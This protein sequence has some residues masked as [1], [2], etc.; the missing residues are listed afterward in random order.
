MK[1]SEA[2]FGFE[3]KYA[4]SDDPKDS[5]VTQQVHRPTDGRFYLVAEAKP[6]VFVAKRGWAIDASDPYVP[7]VMGPDGHKVPLNKAIRQGHVTTRAQW[8]RPAAER[9]EVAT[10]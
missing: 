3:V 5:F 2:V 4:G 9:S 10:A 8:E 6:V 1:G 7:L